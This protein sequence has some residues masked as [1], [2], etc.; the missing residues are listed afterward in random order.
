M[1]LCNICAYGVLLLVTFLWSFKVSLSYLAHA[2]IQWCSKSMQYKYTRSTN[3]NEKWNLR[4]DFSFTFLFLFFS[5]LLFNSIF[6]VQKILFFLSFLREKPLSVPLLICGECWESFYK[7][8]VVITSRRPSK[9][10]GAV[11]MLTT[12][13]NNFQSLWCFLFYQNMCTLFKRKWNFVFVS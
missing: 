11:K 4:K 2:H 6:L 10:C 7:R 12:Y 1:C 3:D 8:G 5:L 13:T 9:L